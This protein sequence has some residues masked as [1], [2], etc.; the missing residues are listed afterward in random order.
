MLNMLMLSEVIQLEKTEAEYKFDIIDSDLFRFKIA[1]SKGNFACIILT[2]NH[3]IADSWALGLVIQEIIKNYNSIKNNEIFNPDTFS[4]L[5]YIKSEKEY[6]NSKKF[7]NDKYFWSQTFSTIPEQATIP[8]SINGVKNISYKAKRL[9]FEL[10]KDIV[11]KINNFCRENKISTFNF[12][13]I[14]FYLLHKS[15][16]LQLRFRVG[17]QCHDDIFKYRT[18][19]RSA[20]KFFR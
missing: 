10:D 6:I 1:I 19:L 3:L 15:D 16:S 8:G 17:F 20:A 4:Y 11:S 13:F 9:S 18:F 5:D 7:T 2:V 14:L 12:F